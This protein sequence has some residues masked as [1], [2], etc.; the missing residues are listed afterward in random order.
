[1]VSVKLFKVFLFLGILSSWLGIPRIATPA[2]NPG[3][4]AYGEGEVTTPRYRPWI[5]S[6]F[7]AENS[8][9]TAN[10]TIKWVVVKS[11]PTADE[12]IMGVLSS[13]SNEVHI[14][15]W[16]GSTWTSNWGTT[17]KIANYRSFD[18]AYEKNSGDVIVVFG[19]ANNNLKY[20][21]RVG[22]TWD[23]T[24]QTIMNMGNVANFVKAES[25]PTSDDIFVAAVANNGSLY[26]LRWDGSS[27]T[28]PIGD[29]ITI[30]GIANK[31]VECFDIAFERSSG[32]AFL[33]WGDDG[34]I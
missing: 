30:T 23:S 21:K 2:N 24:D 20:R 3:I 28:W 31:A 25:D 5:A 19:D 22:G 8:G 13:R 26:A 10:D 4:L 17:T 32:N 34:K 16:N 6:G 18:I 9:Q 15:T 1:M 27:N 12:M 7:G 29:R 14:Q 33:I 11:S